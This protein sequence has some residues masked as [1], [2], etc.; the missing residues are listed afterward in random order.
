MTPLRWRRVFPGQEEEIRNTRY[1]LAGLLPDYPSRADVLTVAS[2]LAANAVRHSASGRG[3]YFAV[4]ISWLARPATIRIAVA[5]GGGP[6]SPAGLAALRAPGT[7]PFAGSLPGASLPAVESLTE[8]GR[9]LRLVRALAL[10]AGLCG[11]ERGRLVWA[12]VRWDTDDQPEPGFPDGYRAALRDVQAVLAARYPEAAIWFGQATMHWWA[13]VGHPAGGPDSR[14]LTAESALE[15]ARLLDLYRA[16]QRLERRPSR[17]RHGA[18]GRRRGSTGPRP[19]I[20]GGPRPAAPA[21]RG[22][23][24]AVRPLAGAVTG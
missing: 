16:R 18:T 19:A 3:G 17:G 21:R 2:E 4:E 12:D 6:A 10:R 11:D 14:L 20:G 22:P 15:L 24:V 8:S 13:M 1:W 7:G 23:R 9:G 5:D